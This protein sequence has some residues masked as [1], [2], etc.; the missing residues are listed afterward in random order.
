MYKLLIGIE[1]AGDNFSAYAPDL[2]GCVATGQNREETEERMMEAIEL[3]IW[4][5]LEDGLQIPWHETS[6]FVYAIH[7]HG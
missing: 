7:K 1:K 4:G 3:H 5:M 2:P 6:A